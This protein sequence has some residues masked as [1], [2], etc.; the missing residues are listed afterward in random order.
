M[1]DSR[2]THD[3]RQREQEQREKARMIAS[4]SDMLKRVPPDYPTWDYYVTNDF[5]KKAAAASKAATNPKSSFKAVL[6]A[7]NQLRTYYHV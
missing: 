1:S 7:Y 4:I 6:E 5:K 2:D 3:A